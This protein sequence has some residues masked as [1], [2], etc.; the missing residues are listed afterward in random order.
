MDLRILH[1]AVIGIAGLGLL[2]PPGVLSAA[3]SLRSAPAVPGFETPI[4]SDVALAPGGTL[5]GR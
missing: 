4:I 3:E 1:Q 5:T 2:V